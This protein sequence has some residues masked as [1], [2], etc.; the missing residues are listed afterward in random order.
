MDKN[1]KVIIAGGVVLVIL[2]LVAAKVF[3]LNKS[4]S[5]V[6]NGTNA[7]PTEEL[8]P[9]VDPSV[10]IDLVATVPGKELTLT[11]SNL[12]EGT[13]DVE[14]S[15][16]YETVKQGIQGVIGTVSTADGETE[17]TKELTLGTCSSGTCVYHDVDGPIR[18][19]LK[20]NGSYGERIFEKDFNL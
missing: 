20:F 11:V 8:I 14:Y 3:F 10:K 18:L 12:P 9:T 1:R 6:Q 15:L 2:L 7:L 13:T 4:A 19:S 17:Y 16:S 5:T